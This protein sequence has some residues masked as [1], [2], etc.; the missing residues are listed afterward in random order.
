ML[1]VS[2]LENENVCIMTQ[3]GIYGEI[4]PEPSEIPWALPLRIPSCSGFI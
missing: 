3:V 4:W 1:E 2:L